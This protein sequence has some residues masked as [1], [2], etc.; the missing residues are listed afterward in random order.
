MTPITTVIPV[1][2]RA[3]VVGRA[4]ESVLTQELPPGFSLK[5][6]VVD[7]GSSDGLSEVLSRFGPNVE[8]IRHPHNIG[9]AAARNTGMS[10][11]DDGFVAF[12]DSDDVWLPGKLRRQLE[13]MRQHGW[14]ASCTAFSL[15]RS[16]RQ[17]VVSPFYPSGVLG[18]ADFVWGCFTCPGSTLLSE[19]SVLAEVGP[20]DVGMRRMEDWDWM[21]RFVEK[22]EMGFIHEPLGRKHLSDHRNQA[23]V[24]AALAMLRAKHEASL[25]GA[26][27]RHFL[28]AMD[29]EMAA[30]HYRSGNV[31]RMMVPCLRSLLRSPVGNQA[32]AL[33]LHNRLARG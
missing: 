2:N 32:L 21:I 18:L 24:V 9:A 10:A 19:R 6:L 12:L 20:L 13:L 1:F 7:D 22:H 3:H 27:R 11:A 4:I 30:A 33:V 14:Q 23:E 31:F 28:A 29:L 16:G 5:V 25:S 17:D 15:A 26:H 8:C